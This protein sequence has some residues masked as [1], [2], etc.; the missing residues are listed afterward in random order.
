MRRRRRIGHYGG[1]NPFLRECELEPTHAY[2]DGS[3][4]PSRGWRPLY[5]WERERVAKRE[6]GVLI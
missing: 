5:Y 2:D 6:Y 3:A 1:W 4:K